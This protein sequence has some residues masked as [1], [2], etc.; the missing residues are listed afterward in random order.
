MSEIKGRPR[1]HI[2][3]AKLDVF[4]QYNPTL[5]DAASLMDVGKDKLLEAIK[6]ER[7]M[8]FSEYR[9]QKMANTRLR[10]VQKA[11]KMAIEQGNA[12]ILIFCL[13]NLCGWADIPNE[14]DKKLSETVTITYKQ[15]DDK[16]E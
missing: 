16:K 6:L 3:W 8:S 9:T 7:G 4:L 10:L 5:E 14:N 12:T 1:K 11:M 2:D 15:K 13:K